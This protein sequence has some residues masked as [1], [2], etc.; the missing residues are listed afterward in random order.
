MSE[1][2]IPVALVTRIKAC[3]QALLT[4]HTL[5]RLTQNRASARAKSLPLCLFATLWTVDLFCPWDSQGRILEWIA[6][7][8]SRGSSYPGIESTPLQ[9]SS[10]QSLSRVWLF[11]T[12]WA[13]A[14]QASMSITNSRSLLKL[15][16]IESVTPPN[17][18]SLLSSSRPCLLCLLNWQAGYHQ[19]HLGTAMESQL[20]FLAPELWLR[21][22]SYFCFTDYAKAFDC[23]EHSKQWKVLKEMGIQII[24]PAS[25]GSLCR[26]RSNS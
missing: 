2:K 5:K 15:T 1:F 4:R 25:W 20:C 11:A 16:S 8:S 13:A 21:K 9:F 12:P 24:S 6:M 23:V 26:S 10:V 3:E 14:C 19:H 17:H 18:L 22:T 7:P